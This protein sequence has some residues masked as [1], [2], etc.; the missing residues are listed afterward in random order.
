[1]VMN[2]KEKIKIGMTEVKTENSINRITSRANPRSIERVVAGSKF[3]F[4]V[5][6]SVYDVD[7]DKENDLN[8]FKYLMECFKLLEDDGLG[9]SISRGYGKIAFRNIN[10]S[11]KTIEHYTGKESEVFHQSFDKIDDLLEK[12]ESLNL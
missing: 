3:N 7:N 4:E 8:Y 9:G 11:T 1:T 5:I 12:I 10:V 6:F 2:W